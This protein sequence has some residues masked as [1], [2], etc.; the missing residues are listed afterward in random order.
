MTISLTLSLTLKD[1]LRK[2]AY[3][4]YE[5]S[6]AGE[7][8]IS[9]GAVGFCDHHLTI[10]MTGFEWGSGISTVWFGR[11]LQRLVSVEHDPRWYAL[12]TRRLK[13]AGLHQVGCRLIPL[14]HDASQPTLP[15]YERT[16]S[17]VRAVEEFPNESLDFVAVDG[18]YRQACVLAA[19][20]KLKRGGMLLV[21]DTNWLRAE[22][23]PVPPGWP[24]IHESAN[25][26]RKKTT[27]VWQKP[28]AV[29]QRDAT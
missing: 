1:V 22:D 4:L 12:V 28:T 13:K 5:L 21:D 19:L 8:W 16:P 17:Y 20:P 3:K 23:W 10:E 27:T 29:E 26:M 2:P 15:R 9:P 11:R 7:P 18:H 25:G 14:E 24:V 6:H